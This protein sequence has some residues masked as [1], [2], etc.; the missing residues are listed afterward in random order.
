VIKIFP[1]DKYFS[2]CVR[3]RAEWKCERC[4]TQYSNPTMA[5]HCAHFHSRGHWSTRFDPANALAQ[6]W[7]CHIYTGNHREEHIKLHKSIIGE[8]EFDR[9]WFDHSRPATKIKSRKAEIA[10][11][12]R[13]EFERMQKLR[14]Q[15]FTGRLEFEAWDASSD[16]RKTVTSRKP[17]ARKS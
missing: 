2:L 16:L 8:L 17:K 14:D 13:L 15:G 11:N 10:R 7:G 12:F 6:C 1:A 3:E 9:I 4:G 5:L